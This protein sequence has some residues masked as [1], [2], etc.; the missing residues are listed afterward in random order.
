MKVT[1]NQINLAIKANGGVYKRSK[2]EMAAMIKRNAE[3]W[4]KE[5]IGPNTWLFWALGIEYD[6]ARKVA[7]RLI[8]GPG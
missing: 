3:M 6:E 5:S 4:G 2:E 7:S 8:D 1:K